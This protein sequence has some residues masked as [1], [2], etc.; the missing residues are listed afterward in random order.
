M[1]SP[2]KRLSTLPTKK[3][4]LD[5]IKEKLDDSSA[6]M[7]DNTAASSSSPSDTPPRKKTPLK[8]NNKNIDARVPGSPYDQICKSSTGSTGKKRKDDLADRSNSGSGKK[9]KPHEA[10]TSVVDLTFDSDS[11]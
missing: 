8:T 3:N 1:A 11:D 2:A 9:Q 10:E 7:E 5:S 6:A 4:P